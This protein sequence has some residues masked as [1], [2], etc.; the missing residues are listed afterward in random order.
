MIGEMAQH[1]VDFGF[2]SKD[3]VYEWV[4]KKSL[5]P[6]KQFRNRSWPDFRMNG[7]MGIEKTSG[8]PWKELTDDYMV[9]ADSD[10]PFQNVIVVAG[11]QEEA[12]VQLLGG[13]GPVFSIDAW[14]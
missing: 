7:W 1:L 8:K 10:D 13:R 11:G 9:P 5:E 14:R 12:S 6:L 4:H 3:E 2:K